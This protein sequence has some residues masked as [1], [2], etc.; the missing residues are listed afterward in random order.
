VRVLFAV[1]VAPDWDNSNSLSNHCG[2]LFEL[3]NHFTADAMTSRPAVFFR[4]EL[5]A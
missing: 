3:V 2:R 1:Q 4:A 5:I